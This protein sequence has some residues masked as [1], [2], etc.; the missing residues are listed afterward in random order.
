MKRN[1]WL[2]VAAAALTLALQ[3]TSTQAG[4]YISIDGGAFLFGD[5]DFNDIGLGVDTGYGINVALGFR[6]ESGFGVELQSGYY[7]NDFSGDFGLFGTRVNIDGD[8]STVPLFVNANYKGTL[9]GPLAIELG[10]GAGVL[11][12]STD[13][14]AT[15]TF[16]GRTFRVSESENS[17][18][19]SIQ[20]L[21][22]LHL[23]LG[24]NIAL[25]AGYR[26]YRLF[27]SEINGHFLGGGLVINF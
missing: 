24:S 6:G 9:I 15:A 17:A 13:A 10:A 26:Y 1:Q 3:P 7:S 27:E 12:G 16:G 11:F 14:S 20:G 19:F 4:P 8:V 18:E 5:V 2:T 23:D 21:A 22:G 25:K